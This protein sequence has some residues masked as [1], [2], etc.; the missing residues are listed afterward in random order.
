M[1]WFNNTLE[2]LSGVQWM[3]VIITVVVTALAVLLGIH[4]PARVLEEHTNQPL[5]RYAWYFV[6][7]FLMV[8]IFISMYSYGNFWNLYMQ[9]ELR[10]G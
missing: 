1:D 5:V 9:S 2:F 4:T 7:T 6:G 10:E 3:R 8:M